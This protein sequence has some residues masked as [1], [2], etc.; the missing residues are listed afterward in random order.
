MFTDFLKEI[1]RNDKKKFV[2]VSEAVSR[3]S[4]EPLNYSAKC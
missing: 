3:N 1:Q 4:E 2:K